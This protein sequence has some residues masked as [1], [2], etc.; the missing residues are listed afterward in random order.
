MTNTSEPF[1]R[2]RFRWVVCALLFFALTINYI[3]R[4]V[5]GI[6]APELQKVFH[7]SNTD[8][9]N[10]AFW[11]EVAYAIGL[12]SFGRVLDWI[13][14]RRGFALS[15]I[16][17]SIAAAIHAVMSTIAGFS[18]ARFLLGLTEAGVFPAAV[19]TTAEWFPRRERA[20]VAGIFNSGSNVGA[21][22]APLAVP[23]LFVTYGWQW[24]FIATG[25][26][27]LVWLAA[28]LWLYRAPE[29]HPRVSPA[30]LA[31]IIQWKPRISC[32]SAS[33]SPWIFT[34][35]CERQMA[36]KGL[37]IIWPAKPTH[38][39]LAKS[40]T[41]LVQTWPSFISTLGAAP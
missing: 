32:S 18:L 8:Y 20:L 27:G 16:G 39:W 35:I 34:S 17:W 23:W 15:I 1:S 29:V 9:T 7:W 10:I 28:W 5:F 26:I 4:L 11:F 19:K 33:L 31:Y 2:T 25:A 41:R 13:G 3:D 21:V 6:L 22:V 38:F 12:A 14:T 30:E 40:G 36:W 24:A 37:P